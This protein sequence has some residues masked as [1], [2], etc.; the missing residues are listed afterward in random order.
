MAQVSYLS[1]SG[2]ESLLPVLC[3]YRSYLSRLD[4][5]WNAKESS[6]IS[7]FQEFHNT[8]LALVSHPWSFRVVPKTIFKHLRGLGDILIFEHHGHS[9]CPWMFFLM[10]IVCSCREHDFGNFTYHFK[11]GSKKFGNP[12]THSG[13]A[14]GATSDT[15][16]GFVTMYDSLV[17]SMNLW[18]LWKS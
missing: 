12:D 18:G 4:I 3:S 6:K 9:K 10:D 1:V 15:G 11:M 8:V 2:S 7:Q 13:K 14:V 16:K 17:I 5:H